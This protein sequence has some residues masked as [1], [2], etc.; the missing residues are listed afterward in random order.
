MGSLPPV[1]V[2]FIGLTGAFKAAVRDVKAEMTSVEKKGA[3][4]GTKFASGAGKAFA[5]ISGAAAYAT[6]KAVGMA[7]KFESE[8]TLLVT[9]CGVAQNQYKNLSKSALDIAQSTG[10]ATDQVAS[11]M[12]IVAKAY[13]NAGDIATITKAA[14]EGA[15]AEGTDMATMA[16]ALTSVMATYGLKGSQA[17]NVTNLL[18]AAAGNSKVQM[19]AFAG[20]L[21]R[22]LPSAFAAKVS[23][24][25]VMSAMA[26]LTHH[27]TSAEEAAQ[28]LAHTIG[29]LQR[30][31]ATASAWMQQLGLNVVT[32]KRQ[33]GQHDGLINVLNTYAKVL[34][35]EVHKNGLIYIS[36]LMHMPTATTALQHA[37]NDMSPALRKVAND[38][39]SGKITAKDYNS[40]IK[41]MGPQAYGMGLQFRSLITSNDGFSKALKSGQPLVM[42]YAEA[43]SRTL[44]TQ[45]SYRTA[46][47]L[48]GHNMVDLVNINKRLGTAY[49]SG[50]KDIETW[51]KTV[52]TARVVMNRLKEAWDAAMITLGTKLLPVLKE[53]GN[54]L[55]KHKTIV[56]DVIIAV[57]AMS[58]AFTALHIAMKVTKTI[59][60]DLS[61]VFGGMGKVVTALRDIYYGVDAA[62]QGTALAEN[63][64]KIA[65]IAYKTVAIATTVVTKAWAGVQWLLNY[66]FRENPIVG[67]VT[68]LVALGVAIYEAYQHSKTFRDIVAD[69]G[70]AFTWVW[71][72]VLEPVVNFFKAHWKQ[73]LE[74]AVAVLAPFIAIPLEIVKHWGAIMNFFK[75][76]GDTVVNILKDAVHWLLRI[77][78]DIIT[79]L[80][81]GIKFVWH[82]LYMWFVGIPLMILTAI[83]NLAK[84]LW[85]KG[86]DLF[87]GFINGIDNAWHSLWSWLS[88]LAN[89]VI[90]TLGDAGS[91]LISIGED[92]MSGLWKGIENGFKSVWNGL[93]N[94]A[95]DIVSGIGSFL[96]I[97][98]PSTVMRDQIGQH[99]MTG[100]ALGITQNSDLPVK[101]LTNAASKLKM[102]NIG[103]HGT[104]GMTGLGLGNG[105][106]AGAAAIYQLNMT[107]QG[108]VM[109]EDDLVKCVE[110]GFAKMGLRRGQSYV[111]Y[112][113]GRSQ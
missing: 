39:I 103:L 6:V 59:T 11:G 62:I 91:W 90:A 34:G 26:L 52:Q 29:T 57:V 33:L 13:K 30:P 17:V 19:E 75:A 45:V 58:L 61:A 106:M 79:G 109:T 31:N 74:I 77:G 85:N 65:M 102:G 42:T 46:V 92:I 97:N 9:A 22:V 68:I 16:N 24:T 12:Y 88:N 99:I 51:G 93:K 32:L 89:I 14:A 110:R 2:E 40:E 94:V 47:Q 70:K 23:L 60:K 48:T 87:N 69:I 55:L 84:T 4:T 101:A 73:A 63:E 81:D 72:N 98:S 41:T 38:W 54:F 113:R 76:L 21:S 7:S 35:G 56:K 1:F 71:H 86:V 100:L 80:W 83:G 104:L 3:G 50:G 8:M 95:G 107:V 36:D 20:S 25:N 64:S 66:A 27:G 105:G 78:K 111:S 18:V 37:L 44:G 15:T 10:V 49:K 43:L 112:A 96:G 5:I 53:V 108:S 67:F 82:A 28:E